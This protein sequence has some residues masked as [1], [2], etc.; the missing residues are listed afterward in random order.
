MKYL[1]YGVA[2]LC[3]SAFGFGCGSSESGPGTAERVQ[4]I[5]T[6][7]GNAS[8]GA[9]LYSDRCSFC[10]G[11]NGEGKGSS[12]SISE[13]LG[14][15]TDEA[16]LTSIIDGI[17]SMPGLGSQLEDQEFADILAHIKTLQ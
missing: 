7:T 10:H 6:L 11:N 4:T 16:A 8:S 14:P 17:G 15:I 1:V 2:L 3:S 12:P 9:T 5:V 13:A